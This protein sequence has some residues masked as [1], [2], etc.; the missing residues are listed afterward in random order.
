MSLGRIARRELVNVYLA[1][2]LRQIFLNTHSRKNGVGKYGSLDMEDD[3]ISFY[4]DNFLPQM[5][6][7]MGRLGERTTG[8][9]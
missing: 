7:R 1:S 6:R 2:R 5:T 3:E 8:D 9:N 4:C